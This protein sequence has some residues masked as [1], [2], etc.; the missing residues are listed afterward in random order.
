LFVAAGQGTNTLAYSS[1][2]VNW[3]GEGTTVL[4]M[5]MGVA[6]NQ[7][8][9]STIFAPNLPPTPVLQLPYGFWVGQGP[10][11]WPIPSTELCGRAWV[12][13]YLLLRETV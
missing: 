5:G 8:V 10:T 2:G 13:P 6:A 7:G 1:N 12:K 4:S 11:L 9:G 3:T